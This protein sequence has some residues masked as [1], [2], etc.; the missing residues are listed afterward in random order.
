MGEL[1][2]V[3][4][5]W[6]AADGVSR[7]YLN[8]VEAVKVNQGG[9]ATTGNAYDTDNAIFVG[10][11]ISVGFF[12]GDPGEAYEDS[13]LTDNPLAYWR[14]SETNPQLPADNVGSLGAAADGTYSAEALVGADSLIGEI[15]DHALALSSADDESPFQSPG[16]EKSGPHRSDD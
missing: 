10:R 2:H 16:F 14:L 6:N 15:G 3:V 7:T 9:S 11:I 4:T 8:G 13:V 12:V 1:V 5:T